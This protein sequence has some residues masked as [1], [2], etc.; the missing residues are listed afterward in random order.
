MFHAIRKPRP[1]VL[2]L[3]VYRHRRWGKVRISERPDRNE[4]P[5]R[6]EVSIPIQGC[7]TI[8]AE[9][10]SNLATYLPV[11]LEDLAEAFNPDLRLREG[12]TITC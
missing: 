7:S 9:V 11:S 12:G 6:S 3:F 1:R 4:I 10:E 8:G 5:V 2:R